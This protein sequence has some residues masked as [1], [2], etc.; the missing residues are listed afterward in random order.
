MRSASSPSAPPRAP[1]SSR[2]SPGGGGSS[3]KCA[4]R[5]SDHTERRS[6][7][8]SRIDALALA[9]A[10]RIGPWAYRERVARFGSAADAFRA[11]VDRADRERLRA[12]AVRITSDGERCGARLVL[13][14]DVDYPGHV[15][16]L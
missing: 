10:P 8:E 11:T 4:E 13:L 2:S 16:H 5:R 6:S 14:D 3:S 15:R 7:P 1:D 9:L 12:E